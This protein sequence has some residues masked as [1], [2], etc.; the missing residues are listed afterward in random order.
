MRGERKKLGV[1]EMSQPAERHLDLRGGLTGEYLQ[2]S[3]LDQTL[4]RG[5]L[6]I[7]RY[8]FLITFC[9]W[10]CFGQ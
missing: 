3:D 4:N 8:L 6:L 10:I 5:F 7:Q 1:S 2:I 9:L